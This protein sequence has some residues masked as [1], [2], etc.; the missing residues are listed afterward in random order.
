MLIVEDNENIREILVPMLEIWLEEKGL[1]ADIHETT[2]GAEA[3]DWVG[4]HGVPDM[5]LLDVRMPVMNG[6]EF[7][8]QMALLGHDIRSKTLLLTGYADDLEQHLGTD[9]LL[10]RHLRKPFMAPELFKQLDLLT[11]I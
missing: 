4:T 6:S 11:D 5:L 7:L 10:I 8:H 1:K 3:L 9:S 2:N